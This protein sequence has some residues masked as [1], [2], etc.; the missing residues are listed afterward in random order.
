MM[1]FVATR[2][3]TYH[4]M[5]N[6][7]MKKKFLIKSAVALCENEK[8]S[9]VKLEE[10]KDIVEDRLFWSIG[11]QLVEISKPVADAIDCIEGDH[12]RPGTSYEIV[13]KAFDETL[14]AIEVCELVDKAKEEL[15]EVS[16][17]FKNR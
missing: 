5:I 13:A 12:C 14:N 16:K 2:W 3:S 17:I 4:T 9:S 15:T 6:S 11:Q 1:H 7:V 10:V 8:T